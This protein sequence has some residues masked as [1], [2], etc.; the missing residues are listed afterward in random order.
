MIS[1]DYDAERRNKNEKQLQIENSI[2]KNKIQREKEKHIM[3][4]SI[5]RYVH[6][7]MLKK[8]E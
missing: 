6:I 3:K 2:I 1:F 7:K 5:R 4:Y 8:E